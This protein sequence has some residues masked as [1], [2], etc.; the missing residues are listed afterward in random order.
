MGEER[1]VGAVLQQLASVMS[2]KLLDLQ[3]ELIE[4]SGSQEGLLSFAQLVPM[5]PLNH[6]QHLLSPRSAQ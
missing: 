4:L 2:Q 1:A 3:K 6:F 5:Q